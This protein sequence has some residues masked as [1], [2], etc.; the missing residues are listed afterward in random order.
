MIDIIIYLHLL[1]Q[2]V[3]QAKQSKAKQSKGIK[4]RKKKKIYIK[5]VLNSSLNLYNQMIILLHISENF[6]TWV[7]DNQ[8]N[9]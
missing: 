7:M 2:N 8:V 6:K 5:D 4:Q 3:A 9:F 1:T